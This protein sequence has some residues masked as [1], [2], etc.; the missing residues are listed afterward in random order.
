MCKPN[1]SNIPST[2]GILVSLLSAQSYGL[3][4]QVEIDDSTS[5]PDREWINTGLGGG[6]GAGAFLVS[7]SFL[8]GSSV[9]SGRLVTAFTLPVVEAR[10]SFSFTEIAGLY[11][12][13]FKSRFFKASISAGISYVTGSDRGDFSTVGF[14]ID[15]EATITPFES[16][17]FAGKV[18]WSAN[19][20]KPWGGFAICLQFGL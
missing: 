15:I 9:Y 12:L 8:S 5:S 18:F 1:E 14:P 2:G 3:A 13:G 19:S 7:Y 16:F 20:K 10:R 4:T 17:G 11:G 6:K